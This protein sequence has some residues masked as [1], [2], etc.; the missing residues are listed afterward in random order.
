MRRGTTPTIVFH[1]PF[2]VS[3]IHNCEVYFAQ[4]DELIIEKK[5]SDCILSGATLSVT[6]TQA[7]TLAFSSDGK[8]EMQLRF[9]FTDGSVDA[10]TIVKEKANKILKDGEINVD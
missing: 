2:D 10:T 8:V 4:N 9:V 6:L 1:L 3:T 7:D 5:M